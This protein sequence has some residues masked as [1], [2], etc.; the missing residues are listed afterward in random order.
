MLVTVNTAVDHFLQKGCHQQRAHSG[1]RSI[2]PC[3]KRAF[4]I[5][6]RLQSFCQIFQKRALPVEFAECLCPSPNKLL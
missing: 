5:T 2:D 3:G 1:E 6:A 4:E